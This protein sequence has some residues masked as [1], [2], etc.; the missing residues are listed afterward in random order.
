MVAD[1]NARPGGDKRDLVAG[2]NMLFNGRA[3]IQTGFADL[4]DFDVAD[5]FA[6]VG[7]SIGKLKQLIGIKIC[8]IRHNGSSCSVKFYLFPA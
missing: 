6:A 3:L 8:H 4:Y 7:E 1:Q 5:P 2:L